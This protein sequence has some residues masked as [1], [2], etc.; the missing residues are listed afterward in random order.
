MSEE[1]YELAS[2]FQKALQNAPDIRGIMSTLRND[3]GCQL[4]Q[5]DDE[6]YEIDLS[7]VSSSTKMHIRHFVENMHKTTPKAEPKSN[8]TL[9][10]MRLHAQLIC[11]AKTEERISQLKESLR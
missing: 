7:K 3:P 6:L 9:S 8:V 4:C 10:A 5:D 11:L 1:D 2:A